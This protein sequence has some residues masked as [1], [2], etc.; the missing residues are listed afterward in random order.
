M[1][2]AAGRARQEAADLGS[3]LAAVP[4]FPSWQVSVTLYQQMLE[5]SS[6]MRSVWLD[7]VNTAT[8]E[9][10]AW[11][12]GMC[13]DGI[14]CGEA[15]LAAPDAETRH[16]LRLEYAQ[17]TMEKGFANALALAELMNRRTSEIMELLARQTMRTVDET[18]QDQHRAA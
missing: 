3:A 4:M 9:Q 6:R 1:N 7:S 10:L 14:R 5:T 13:D 2:Q 16:Q 17:R 8:Q 15:L 11:L 18:R 12:Q